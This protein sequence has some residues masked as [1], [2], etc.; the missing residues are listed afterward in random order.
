MDMNKIAWSIKGK[1]YTVKQTAIQMKNFVIGQSLT[2]KGHAAYDYYC[3][4]I[5]NG[6]EPVSMAELMF[7][8]TLKEK[9]ERLGMTRKDAAI[10][11]AGHLAHHIAPWDFW[12]KEHKVI[13]G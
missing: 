8:D 12:K 11:T 7:E 5:F 1:W 3:K 10:V 4:V 13:G 2:P 6:Y 9:I